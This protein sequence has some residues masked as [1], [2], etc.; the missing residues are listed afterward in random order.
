MHVFALSSLSPNGVRCS[1]GA[2]SLDTSSSLHEQCGQDP[3]EAQHS[4]PFM[5]AFS[6]LPCF[7]ASGLQRMVSSVCTIGRLQIHERRASEGSDETGGGCGRLRC[8]GA[9]LP[10]SGSVSG[11]LVMPGSS[12]ASR[13]S[14]SRTLALLR[15]VSEQPLTL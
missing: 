2:L 12:T 4:L 9:G 14:V 10:W 8:H 13:Q 5:I 11:A 6:E 7:T 1:V 15:P 3:R